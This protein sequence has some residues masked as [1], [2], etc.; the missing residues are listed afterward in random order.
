MALKIYVIMPIYKGLWAEEKKKH[1][2]GN[3]IEWFRS[4]P[5]RIKE[6]TIGC[7]CILVG[8]FLILVLFNL[9]GEFGETVRNFLFSSEESTPIF[10]LTFLILIAFV[11]FLGIYL[12]TSL[13]PISQTRLWIGTVLGVLSFSTFFSA[14]FNEVTGGLLGKNIFNFLNETFGFFV[15]ILIPLTILGSLW[16]LKIFSPTGIY[17]WLTNKHDDEDDYDDEEDY[18]EEEEED[19]YEEEEEEDD[20]EED[21]GD[22]EEEIDE[23]EDEEEEEEID[24]EEEEEEEEETTN[25][26]N[27]E[28]Y[29]PPPI[30]LL[31]AQKGKGV[32]ENTKAQAMNIRRTLQNFKVDV[33]IEGIKVGPTFTRY[34]LKPSE[35]V[36]LNKITA[37]QQNLELALAAHPIRIEAPIPGKSLVGIEVPNSSRAIIGLK[38]LIESEEFNETKGDLPLVVGKNVNGETFARSLAKMPHILVAGTTG[39]GKSVLI[40]NLILSLMFSYSPKDLRFIFIDPKRVELTLYKGI[41]HLFTNPITDPKKALQA[42]SWCVIE[43]ERRYELL[44]KQEARDINSYNKSIKEDEEYLPY[45]VV[46]IDELADLMQNFPREIEGNI[47]RIAQKSRAVGIHLIISTQRP[48]VNIITG[49]VKANIPVRIA[50]QV[51]SGIDSRTILDGTGAENLVGN[52]DLLFSSSEFKKPLRIQSAFVF[53]RRS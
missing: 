34:S 7:L 28:D 26:N 29:S 41:A 25:R 46:V 10:G 24:E 8:I 11:I 20:Y 6:L 48:S 37:L 51:A 21:E 38:T 32:A 52:G 45:L 43:M 50:L 17:N 49:V 12:I 36:R 19:N 30:N 27:Y 39:S 47:V 40:H 1:I 2:F 14:S 9:A 22:E 4:I 18:E 23:D 15:Y 44:E 3:L 13:R 35:G 53:R 31:S 33:E 5:D 16:I 42:L